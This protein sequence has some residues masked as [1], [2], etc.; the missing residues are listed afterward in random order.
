M[1]ILA[2]LLT[3][4]A[5]TTRDFLQ[6]RKLQHEDPFMVAAGVQLFAIPVYLLA[7]VLSPAPI[8]QPGFWSAAGL[9]IIFISVSMVLFATSLRRGEL[10]E[11][12]P[13]LSF[14]PA[15]MLILGP[16]LLGE[17]INLQGTIGVLLI[18]IG[19]YVLYVKGSD[20][21][22]Y[23]PL[24]SLAHSSAARM[25][26][27][28]ALFW[29]ITSIIHKVGIAASSPTFWALTVN[30]GAAFALVPLALI[31]SDKPA[32]RFQNSY[33]GLALVGVAYALMILRWVWTLSVAPASYAVA[34]RRT[35]I[36]LS[37]L[38]GGML[39]IEHDLKQ[40]LEGAGIMVLGAVLIALA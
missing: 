20:D 17:E 5:T 27:L 18:T 14:T 24:V 6:K 4:I 38:V 7:A 35:S 8:I 30:T 37:V 3:A 2:A 28:V 11:T 9:F 39:L 26:L 16:L 13:L 40:H 36:L 22:W 23:A 31:E 29:G 32:K 33:K 21:H 12:I 34:I 25:M 15:F 1:W 19:A 10:G